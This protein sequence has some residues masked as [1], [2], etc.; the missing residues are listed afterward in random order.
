M[1]EGISEG[2]EWDRDG[3]LGVYFSVRSLYLGGFGRL[4]GSWGFLSGKIG[5]D[6][7]IK[8]SNVISTNACLFCDYDDGDVNRDAGMSVVVVVSIAQLHH[9]AG[10]VTVPLELEFRQ[11]RHQAEARSLVIAASTDVVNDGQAAGE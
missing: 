10:V 1:S 3:I 6:R 9:I 4:E 8:K 11:T 7:Y 5:L 2:G